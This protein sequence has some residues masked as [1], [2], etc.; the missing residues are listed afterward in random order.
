MRTEARMSF[1]EG[2]AS[3]T[4]DNV[5]IKKSAAILRMTEF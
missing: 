1:A 3:A 5:K 4:L 2:G